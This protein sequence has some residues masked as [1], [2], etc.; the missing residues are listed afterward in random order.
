M[1]FFVLVVC[2]IKLLSQECFVAVDSLKGYYTGDCKNGKANGTGTAKG[3]DSYTGNFKDGYPDGIGTYTWA[4]GNSY[5]G[6]WKD[7]LFEGE[8]TFT[9]INN[10][11]ND[12]VVISGFWQKGK[13]INKTEAS[14]PF[15][16]VA[17]TNG[18]NDY[19]IKKL[20]G[21]IRQITI[22]VKSVTGGAQ[23]INGEAAKIAVPVLTNIQLIEG[24]YNQEI[25]DERPYSMFNKYIL[26]EVSFPFYAILSFKMPDSSPSTKQNVQQLSIEL[27]QEGNY[28]LEVN[29]D[30]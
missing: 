24:I 10:N 14:A 30:E 7:G 20:R 28:F 8:G 1:T 6:H 18:I 26:Q 29:L 25:P 12:S 19:N 22:I 27:P 4:N 17:L 9:K 23:T 5:T 13:F 15:K 3:I 11:E 21:T 16:V 2:S